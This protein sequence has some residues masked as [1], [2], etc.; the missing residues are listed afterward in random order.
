MLPRSIVRRVLPLFAAALTLPGAFAHAEAPAV[1]LQLQVDL[2]VK[3]LEYA[4]APS[5]PP[6]GGL[7]RIAIVVKKDSLESRHAGTELKVAFGRVATIAGV[8]HEETVI[9]WSTPAAVA[10]QLKRARVFAVY[11]TP[12][13]GTDLVSLT[14]ALEGVP[15][16]TIAAIGSDVASGAILG[17][18]LT[19]GRPKM[20][21]NLGQARRQGV[22]FRAS[23]VKLMRL[24]D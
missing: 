19:S 2:T 5:P 15:T 3:L 20:L 7:M 8:P 24:V 4:E 6:K 22:V 18:E 13:L 16:I 11:L 9:E 21:F 1:P 17:F 12:D 14:R 10:E 23:V